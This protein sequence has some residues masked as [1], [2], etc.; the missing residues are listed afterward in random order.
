MAA[1]APGSKIK[2]T[3][4]DPNNNVQSDEKPFTAEAGRA[5]GGL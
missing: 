1:M 3:L 4:V 2:T 5:D